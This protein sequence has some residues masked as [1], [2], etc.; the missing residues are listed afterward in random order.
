[1][2]CLFVKRLVINKI[3]MFNNNL[4]RL[5]WCSCLSYDM[6]RQLNNIIDI[7][8]LSLTSFFIINLLSI[9]LYETHYNNIHNQRISPSYLVYVYVRIFSYIY[10]Y[11]WRAIESNFLG[12]VC[13]AFFITSYSIYNYNNYNDCLN[14]FSRRLLIVVI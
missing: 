2:I 9:K 10:I 13:V 7:N 1:M 8:I 3:S 12:Y 14:F 11:W 6:F 4:T 5:T